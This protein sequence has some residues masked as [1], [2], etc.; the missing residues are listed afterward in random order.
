M[1]GIERADGRFVRD[2][3]DCATKVQGADEGR[4]LKGSPPIHW[5]GRY[6]VEMQSRYRLCARYTM[7]S[8]SS[9][10]TSSERFLIFAI[11]RS[12]SR[13]NAGLM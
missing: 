8:S 3:C 12:T 1:W 2:R 11:S 6:G 10:T 7:I 13:W 5:Q 4:H 9:D